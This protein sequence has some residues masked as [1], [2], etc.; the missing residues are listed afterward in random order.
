[1]SNTESRQNPAPPTLIPTEEL[2]VNLSNILDRVS[3]GEVF[4][5]TRRGTLICKIEPITPDE[6]WEMAR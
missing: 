6:M 4:V 1:M 5:L 2:R 3:Q